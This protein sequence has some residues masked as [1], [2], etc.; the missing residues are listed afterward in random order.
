MMK[1]VEIGAPAVLPLA[2]APWP[3]ANRNRIA[4]LAFTIQHPPIHLQVQSRTD[5]RLQ[6]TGPRADIG[7]RW[8]ERF[9]AQQKLPVAATIEIELAIPAYMGLGSAPLLGL[10]IGHALAALHDRSLSAAA[11]AEALNLPPQHGL[12]G[13]GFDQG[14]V[15]LAGTETAV[16]SALPPLY[17]R[18]TVAHPD[19][20]A[21]A[22]VLY[23]PRLATAPGYQPDRDWLAAYRQ[24]E[25]VWAKTAVSAQLQAAWDAVGQDD[26]EAFGT[27]LMAWQPQR[28]T[29]WAQAGLQQTEPSP[30]RQ[31]LFALMAAEGAYAWGQSLGGEALYALVR[32]AEQTIKLRQAL[33]RQIGF[34]GGILLATITDNQ[35]ARLVAHDIP[36]NSSL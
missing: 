35:G 21:W 25:S 10:A 27:H 2:A 1:Q 19:D 26:I 12:A 22:F 14:G 34:T 13:W 28:Q 11:L 18:Q 31:Q 6:V 33:R 9:L 32:G 5:G 17:Q 24:A 30:D 7:R 29:V 23:L 8:A 3:T 16:S 36:Y 4:I 15:L 20:A